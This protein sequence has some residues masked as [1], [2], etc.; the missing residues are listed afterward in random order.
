M[1]PDER[2]SAYLWDMLDAARAV[3]EFTSSENSHRSFRHCRPTLR[4]RP[5]QID[6]PQPAVQ[7]RDGIA[8]RCV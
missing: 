4:L 2:D 6:R 7:D 8:P 3:Q 5:I 1:P